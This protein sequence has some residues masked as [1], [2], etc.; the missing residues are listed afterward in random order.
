MQPPTLS[1]TRLWGESPGPFSLLLV[2]FLFFILVLLSS[3]LFVALVKPAE[4]ERGHSS[5]GRRA[6]RDERNVSHACGTHVASPFISFFLLPIAGSPFLNIRRDDRANS[7]RTC[8][9]HLPS[10]QPPGAVLH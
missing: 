4:H 10:V 6:D 1:A 7:A 8:D 3:C 5:A 2:W 9:I